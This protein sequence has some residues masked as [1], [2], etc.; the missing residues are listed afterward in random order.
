MIIDTTISIPELPDNQV[1]EDIRGNLTNLGLDSGKIAKIES[2]NYENLTWSGSEGLPISTAGNFGVKTVPGAGA[3][4]FTN[5]QDGTN[6][7]GHLNTR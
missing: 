2:G 6:T 5:N 3:F 4:Y 7:V 1:F